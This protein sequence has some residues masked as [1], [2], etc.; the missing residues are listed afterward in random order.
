[1]TSSQDSRI[2]HAVSVGV[3]RHFIRLGILPSCGQFYPMELDFQKSSYLCGPVGT[4]KTWG[5]AA[6][7]CD[8]LAAGYT[9]RLVNWQW[10][11]LEVRDTY[12]AAGKETEMDV[13]K[14][15]A[16]VQVLC[17]DD[18]GA[19]KEVAGRESEAARVLCYTLL[20]KRYANGVITHISSNDPLEVLT[21]KYDAR[22]GRRITELCRGPS[23]KVNVLVLKDVV[24]SQ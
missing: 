20:D 18:L 24:I 19:G 11:Q 23:G 17:L 13:L 10:F 6:M 7:C 22:I 21:K 15:Y 12:K 16:G 1:M 14:R 8:A 3:G 9:A 2:S 4:G 5:L